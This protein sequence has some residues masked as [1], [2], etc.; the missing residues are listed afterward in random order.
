MATED[1]SGTVML[2]AICALLAW[3]MWLDRRDDGE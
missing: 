2:I 1:W 3:R